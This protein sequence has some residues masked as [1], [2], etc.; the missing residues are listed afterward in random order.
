[1]KDILTQ[2]TQGTKNQNHRAS[3]QQNLR[4]RRAV[5]WVESSE[6]HAGDSE[7]EARTTE[8]QRSEPQQKPVINKQ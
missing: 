1:M 7:S 8:P 4:G 2:S 6:T 3:E 5:G